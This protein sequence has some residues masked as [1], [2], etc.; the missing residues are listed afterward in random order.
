MPRPSTR[1]DVVILSDAD[2]SHHGSARQDHR[3]STSFSAADLELI[4]TATQAERDAAA[5]QVRLEGDWEGEL[6][7]LQKALDALIS[8]YID[9]APAT[10]ARSARSAT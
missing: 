8:K 2:P 4:S 6:P 9:Q 10:S 1:P 3:D 5:T 7:A